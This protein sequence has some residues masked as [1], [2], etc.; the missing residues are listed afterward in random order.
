M[1]PPGA[2][3]GH[4]AVGCNPIA[5]ARRGPCFSADTLLH[6]ETGPPIIAEEQDC[7]GAVRGVETK[8]SGT[9]AWLRNAFCIA[10]AYALLFQ[11][12]FTGISAERMSFAAAGGQEMLCISDGTNTDPGK[13]PPAD[14][15]SCCTICAFHALTPLLPEAF[16]LVAPALSFHATAAMPAARVALPRNARR[17]PRTSQGPP[18]TT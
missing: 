3:D 4:P 2:R 7:S 18:L 12:V 5:T 13:T 16:G 11:V 15:R 17:E 1:P 14:H 8:R 10:L 6:P 9:T